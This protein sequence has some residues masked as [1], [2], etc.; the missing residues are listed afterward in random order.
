MMCGP[1]QSE[2]TI[3]KDGIGNYKTF[4]LLNVNQ[5]HVFGWLPASLNMLVSL[6]VVLWDIKRIFEPQLSRA[7][8]GIREE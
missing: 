7:K 2:G 5:M 1:E 3:F 4:R 8:Y 6:Y